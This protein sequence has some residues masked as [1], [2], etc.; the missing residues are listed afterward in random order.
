MKVNSFMTIIDLVSKKLRFLK[1]MQHLPEG[2]HMQ[3]DPDKEIR[4][5]YEIIL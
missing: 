5:A 4:S 2:R 3:Q 1:G